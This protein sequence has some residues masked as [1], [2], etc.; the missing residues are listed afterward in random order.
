MIIDAHTNVT[1]QRNATSLLTNAQGLT[2]SVD[3]EV[4]CG[5]ERI[6]VL[7]SNGAKFVVRTIETV[8]IPSILSGYIQST[9]RVE[10]PSVEELLAAAGELASVDPRGMSED[11][12]SELFTVMDSYTEAERAVLLGENMPTEALEVLLT[13]LQQHRQILDGTLERYPEQTPPATFRDLL[14]HITNI[15]RTTQYSQHSFG[16]EPFQVSNGAP[17]VTVEVRDTSMLRTRNNRPLAAGEEVY[18]GDELIGFVESL[19]NT[20]GGRIVMT[21]DAYARMRGQEETQPAL[22]QQ[23]ADILMTPSSEEGAV[24]RVLR[25]IAAVEEALQ[26]RGM[27]FDQLTNEQAADLLLEAGIDADDFTAAV[28]AIE[29]RDRVAS[30]SAQPEK[31]KPPRRRRRRVVILEDPE[32]IEEGEDELA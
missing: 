25:R 22:T 30:Q 1:V 18:L 15:E 29:A 6:G 13:N 5:D 27:S 16:G 20:G 11:R 24:D 10:R 26:S 9:R 21:Q 7:V 31:P 12:A 14:G 32:P 19:D 23:M 8:G 2:P 28:D 17:E 3:E 4:F